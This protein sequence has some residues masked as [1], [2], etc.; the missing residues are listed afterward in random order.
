[1]TRPSKENIRVSLEELRREATTWWD[2]GTALT[3][4]VPVTE[5]GTSVTPLQMG[6]FAGFHGAFVANSQKVS[7]LAE[8]GRDEARKIS[9]LLRNIA[10][11][12]EEEERV[13]AGAA[14]SIHEEHGMW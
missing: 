13:H 10:T 3:S 6:I 7:R 8:Q 9:A 14:K 11:V 1:M 2:V 5:Y 12:Y 4:I